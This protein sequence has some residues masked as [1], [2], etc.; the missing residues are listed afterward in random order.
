V[1][2]LL[3]F[4]IGGSMAHDHPRRIVPARAAVGAIRSSSTK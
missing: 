1:F 2:S 3:M 4:F